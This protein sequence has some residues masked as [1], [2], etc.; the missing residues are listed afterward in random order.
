MSEIIRR[1]RPLPL[2]VRAF[3]TKTDKQI[4]ER[5]LDFA[6]SSQ[7]DWLYNFVLWATLNGH[8]VEIIN[9]KD[10]IE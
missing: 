7:K 4:R 9:S 8:C 6:N 10:D 3:E 5:K 2:I 1:H